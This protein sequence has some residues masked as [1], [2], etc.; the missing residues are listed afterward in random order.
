M[1][2]MQYNEKSSSGSSMSWSVGVGKSS[3]N[4]HVSSGRSRAFRGFSDEICCR[5][6]GGTG[7]AGKVLASAAYAGD[8]S[9]LF[10]SRAVEREKK[11][12]LSYP[13]AF[14]LPFLN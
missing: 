6:P 8:G 1:N 7:L 4:G 2:V 3:E 12:S 11:K 13:L 5:G 14:F 9:S 10:P